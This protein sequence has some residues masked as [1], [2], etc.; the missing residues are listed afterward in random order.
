MDTILY[1]IIFL[2]LISLTIR[3]VTNTNTCKHHWKDF[4]IIKYTPPIHNR[5][6][7]L[8]TPDNSTF[9]RILFGFTTF[10][11]QCSKCNQ[12]KTWSALGEYK[13]QILNSDQQGVTRDG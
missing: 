3:L 11:Q 6:E 8:S 7:S 1:I 5:L 12:V 9:D 10:S 4:K 13:V 2:W